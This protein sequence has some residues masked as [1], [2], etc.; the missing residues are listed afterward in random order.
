MCVARY[1]EKSEKNDDLI[2]QTCINI[3]D[4]TRTATQEEGGICHGLSGALVVVAGAGRLVRNES[5][6]R[7]ASEVFQDFISLNFNTRIHQD[8]IVDASW[9]TGTAGLIWANTAI[10]EKPGINPLL[11][12]DSR[13][14]S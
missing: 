3:L 2:A 6:L 4:W 12:I 1:F 7:A 11:P 14:F 13:L 5:I 10:K 9:L 8:F